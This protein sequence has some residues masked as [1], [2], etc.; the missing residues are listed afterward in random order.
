MYLL[1]VEF[2]QQADSVVV[3]MTTIVEEG[4]SFQGNQMTTGKLAQR[5]STSRLSLRT[6]Y[7]GI[8]YSQPASHTDI[9]IYLPTY[10]PTYI[11]TDR[12]TA[13]SV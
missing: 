4:V 2:V 9:H 7:S 11:Q 12:Q 6:H 3:T 8:N 5:H 10:L 1:P 13:H